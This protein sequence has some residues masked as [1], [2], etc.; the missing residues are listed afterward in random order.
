MAK[1]YRVALDAGHGVYTP[2]KQTPDGIKEWTLN[3]RVRDKTV[4]LLRDYNVEFIFPDNDEGTTDESLTS[5]RTMYVNARVDAAVSIHHN[6]LNGKW[7]TATGVEVYVD[8]NAT[9]QDKALAKAIYDRLPMYC[10]LKG[11]GIKEANWTVINQNTVPAVLVE[12]GFMDST[13]DYDI[14]TSERGQ[15]AY[16]KA[17]AEG[18]IEFLK[19]EKIVV[20]T[21]PVVTVYTKEQFIRDVQSATGSKVDGKAGSETLGNTVTVSEKVNRKHKVV[22]F[23]QKRLNALGYDCGEADGTAGPKFTNAV[24]R[25]QKEVLGYKNC[26]GEVTAKGKMWKSLLGMI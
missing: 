13:T 5:R 4:E 25:Y 10:S 16:A 1:I 26:D 11:R 19:L 22:R 6:A 12:G 17:I 2:G 23:L 9:D 15:M 20:R 3:D 8:I 21:E 14:I 18:L 24:N 7:N